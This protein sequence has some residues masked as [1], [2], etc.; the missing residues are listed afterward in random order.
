MAKKAPGMFRKT[1]TE[2][3]FKRKLLRFVE[4]AGDREFLESCFE[5]K[6]GLYR[7]KDAFADGSLP[8]GAADSGAAGF[9][10]GGVQAIKRLKTLEKAIK[11]NRKGAVKILPI[12]ALAA[13]IGGGAFFFITLMDPLLER[14]L[15]RG[16]ENVFEAKCDV[17][18]FHLGLLRFRIGIAAV[19]VANRD[20]PM[21]NLFETGRIEIRLKP[22]AVLRGKVYIEELR[23]D[24][25]RFGTPRTVSGALPQYAAKIAAKRAVPPAP[26]LVDL[27]RFDAMGLLN[28]EY[29]K[30]AAPRAFDAALAAYDEAKTRWEN[31]Y[32]QANA[33]VDELRSSIQPILN[34]NAAAIKTPEDALKIVSDINAMIKTVESAGDEV[35][36]I[37]NG[38]QRDLET[39]QNLERTARE[40]IQSDIDHLKSY[41]DLG[42][43]NALQALEPSL[44][45]L[46]SDEA[47]MYLMYG[48]RAL[49][50]LDKLKALQAK[51]PKSEPKPP[52][53]QGFKGRTVAFP[54][55]TYPVFFLE[56]AAS[57]FTLSGWNWDFELRA[58]SSDPDLSGRPTELDLALAEQGSYGRNA[59]FQGAADF[60]TGAAR[61]FRAS[62]EGNNFPLDIRHDLSAAG[63]GGFSGAMGFTV[64]FAGGGNGA[65]SGGAGIGINGP[66]LL[67][68]VGTIAETV[69]EVVAEL[70]KVTL[71]VQYEHPVSGDDTFDITTNIGDLIAAALKRT[72]EKYLKQAQEAIEK[73]LRE[74]LESYLDGKWVSKDDLDAIFAA[75]KGDKTALDRLKTSLEDKLNE[76][77]RKARG[78][79]EDAVKKALQDALPGT[80]SSAPADNGSTTGGTLKPP[81][82]LPGFKLPF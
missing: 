12:A 22:Q 18:G 4:Q 43:G 42:S 41:L 51:I 23:A 65:V 44:R 46:L 57:D 20:E 82:G 36:G 55:Q 39:A 76:A 62:L 28:R 27:A 70:D 17:N 32:E 53:Q 75:V 37:V 11:I 15:E 73:A 24:S 6:D 64:N 19:T 50:A 26:P 81:Q 21:K 74:K 35:N 2:K 78:A 47:Q 14:L 58:V 29:D 52:K 10:A 61:S 38:V 77:E 72:A 69:A 60:R 67:E 25:L 68:P 7:L 48:R 9:T 71:G 16:L 30:L 1:Y 40:A 5:L 66:R 45:E 80:G 49:E 8:D 3:Q 34:I 59:R 79:A 54:S 13:L 63:I 56:T 31:Q 33:K